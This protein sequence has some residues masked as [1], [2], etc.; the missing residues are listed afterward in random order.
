MPGVDQDAARFFSSVQSPPNFASGSSPYDLSALHA[1]LPSVHPQSPAQITQHAQVA[2][3]ATDFLQQQPPAA[4][5][6]VRSPV[7]SIGP[8]FEQERLL[9]SPN[10]SPGLGIH[11][12][13]KCNL[14]ETYAISISPYFSGHI[15]WSPTTMGF[16]TRPG[17][18]PMHNLALQTPA[19][20]ISH[21]GWHFTILH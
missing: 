14:L 5:P 16:A 1:S 17:P 6:L 21:N 19:K 2:Q 4:V 15:G 13:G 18:M 12:Q 7:L 20:S 10:Q 3:W 9:Q 11:A 8:Q